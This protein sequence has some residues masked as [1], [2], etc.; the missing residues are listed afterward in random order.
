MAKNSML[1]IPV[2]AM[3]PTGLNISAFLTLLMAGNGWEVRVFLPNVPLDYSTVSASIVMI[4][5]GSVLEMAYISII[6]AAA[7]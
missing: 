2:Q 3:I 1:P 4:D 6:I 5:C 7:L